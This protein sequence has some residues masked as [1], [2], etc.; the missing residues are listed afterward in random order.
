M[1]DPTRRHA[2]RP[3]GRCCYL[4]VMRYRHAALLALLGA[5]VA[6]RHRAAPAEREADAPAPP[7]AGTSA[8]FC[9]F[10]PL[11][12]GG[13]LPC[14]KRTSTSEE[15]MC[16]RPFAD[17]DDPAAVQAL[18]CG[19]DSASRLEESALSCGAA[20]G[21]PVAKL[22]A[23]LDA[24]RA[25]GQLHGRCG[26]HDCGTRRCELRIPKGKG[27]EVIADFEATSAGFS[28]TVRCREA[29]PPTK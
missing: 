24:L 4:W 10:M 18:F 16:A 23:R 5:L 1:R 2:R 7:P 12:M 11:D 17:E 19:H 28:G 25:K 9:G 13:P 15:S 22:C 8:P 14:G 3:E 21:V 6:C 26:V 29:P 27:R 20:M